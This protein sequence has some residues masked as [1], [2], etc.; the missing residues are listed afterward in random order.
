M[1]TATARLSN[2][3]TGKEMERATVRLCNTERRGA[4]DSYS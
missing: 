3:Q 2:T 1:K 4:E